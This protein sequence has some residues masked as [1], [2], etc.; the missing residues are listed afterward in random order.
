MSVLAPTTLSRDAS[1]SSI[2]TAS[3]VG[4]DPEPRREYSIHCRPKM[5]CNAIKRFRH[6]LL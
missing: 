5:R 6:N 3:S 4:S 2:V 1:L